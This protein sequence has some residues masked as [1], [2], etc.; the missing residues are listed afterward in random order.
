MYS[1]D[2]EHNIVALL[3]IV[4]NQKRI[5]WPSIDGWINKLWYLYN[6]TLFHNKKKWS[7]KPKEIRRILQCIF[8]RERRQFAKNSYSH[9]MVF[10]KR[11]NYEDRKNNDVWHDFLD[12]EKGWWIHWVRVL[13]GHEII[14]YNAVETNTLYYAFVRTHRTIQYKEWTLCKPWSLVNN[15]S[16]WLY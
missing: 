5:R 2:S 12:G 8:I 14:L 4:K 7:L 3:I 11:Q 10:W 6:R 15:I 13:Y 9:Q 1:K 16:N